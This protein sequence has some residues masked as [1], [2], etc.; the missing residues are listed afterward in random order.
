MAQI[1]SA[2]MKNY[3]KKTKFEGSFPGPVVQWIE[4]AFPKR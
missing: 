3:Q 1:L 2:R 4:R